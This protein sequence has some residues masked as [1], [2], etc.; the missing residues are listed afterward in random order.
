MGGDIVG[1]CHEMRY[2]LSVY[3]LFI[4]SSLL[5]LIVGAE[6][7]YWTA[8][9]LV[10]EPSD[11]VE[12]SSVSAAVHATLQEQLS[13]PGPPQLERYHL[14]VHLTKRNVVTGAS[15]LCCPLLLAAAEDAQQRQQ[16]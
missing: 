13:Q 4:Q 12:D 14:L 16:H 3:I 15:A 2:R 10:G 9:W 5:F 6:K 11:F 7:D 1:L 8:S